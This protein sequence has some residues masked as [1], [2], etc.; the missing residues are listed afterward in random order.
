M[1]AY[2]RI[3]PEVAEA[4][5]AKRPVVALES[6]II[7][8]GMAWPQ[9]AETA[10]ALEAIIREEGAVPATIAVSEGKLRVGLDRAG[11]ETLG[12]EGSRIAKLSVRDLAHALATGRPGATTVASTMRIAAMAGIAVFA[13]GGIGGVHRGAEKSFDISADLN[14][15]SQTNVAVV[16]AGAKAILDLALTLETLE[17]LGVPVVGFGTD[18]FPAFYSRES[19][20]K[21]P[22]RVDTPMELARMMQAKWSIG[23][24]GGIIVANPIPSS[25]EIK[26]TEIT[27]SIERAVAEA[28]AK[29]VGG[30]DLTPFLLGRL[31]D[32]TA[33]R[34][35]AANI[36]LVKN[37][38]RVAAR[39]AK[40][41]AEIT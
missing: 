36:E 19:G 21:C 14:E 22:L 27:P 41:Y 37:N 8:H 15:L 30:K 6:T 24:A 10:F 12:R 17:T 2:L 33:G 29:G 25:D 34:S 4:L 39:I 20:L 28:N 18:E 32:I 26:A 38:A 9:S 3:A 1:N 13:T 11:I 31:A 7:A 23:L 35:L 16:T 40:A 5:H